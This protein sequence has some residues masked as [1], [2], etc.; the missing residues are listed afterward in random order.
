MGKSAEPT[1]LVN[2]IYPAIQG[3]GVHAGDHAIYPDCRPQFIE[4][5]QAAIRLGTDSNLQILAPFV[6]WTKAQIVA[7]GAE[8]GV[9][10]ALTW[11]CYEGRKRHCGRC[12]MCVERREAFEVA[13]VVDPTEYEDAPSEEGPVALQGA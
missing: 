13:G 11:S 3:E 12:G 7:R 1:Y 8:L 4:A 5:M 10:M 9:P 6:Y 2:E